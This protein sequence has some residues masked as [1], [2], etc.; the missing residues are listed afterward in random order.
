MTSAILLETLTKSYGKH[1]G[2]TDLELEVEPGCIL[3][4]LGPNGAG[5]TTTLRVVLDLIRPTRGTSST[6][7]WWSA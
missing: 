5:K 6:S 1:R 7:M 2:V 3:G 4:F